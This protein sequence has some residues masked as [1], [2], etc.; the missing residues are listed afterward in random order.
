MPVK[1]KKRLK[2]LAFAEMAKPKFLENV[3][4]IIKP[5][6]KDAISKGISPV[7][8]KKGLGK[9]NTGGKSRFQKYSQS[10]IDTFGTASAPNKK[11]R[12]VNLNLTGA[13]IKSLSVQKK[14]DYV[15]VEFKDE[16]AVWH[17]D[18][19][20]GKSEVIRRLL[21]TGENEEFSRNIQNKIV[22]ALSEAIKSV[23]K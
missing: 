7:N 10:Y 12:P 4:K 16:K 8:Q 6:I 18:E 13:L 22:E 17:N 2:A 14:K 3:S 23:I 1:I 19:G 9:K 11:E 21:P 15:E 5:L 20:A